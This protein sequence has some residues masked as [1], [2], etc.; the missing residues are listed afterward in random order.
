MI[1]NKKS[2]YFFR[3][4][5][6]LVL[7][8]AAFILAA[9]L[10]QSWD[11]L[12]S[13]N[14]M[15]ILMMGLNFIWYFTST[16][17]NFYDDFITRL[18]AYQVVNIIKS[19]IVQAL[20][21]VLF[22]F[23]LKENL[24]TRNFIVYYS[25]FLFLFI[26]FRSLTFRTVMKRIRQRGKNIR[27]LLIIGTGEV[28]RNFRKLLRENPDFGYNFIGFL[29]KDN[30]DSRELI[31]EIS[32]EL[33]GSYNQ[34]EEILMEKKVEEI[35]IALPDYE[36]FLLDNIIRIC[37][38]NA[39]RIHI[40]PDYFRYVSKRFRISM[41]ENFPIITS[42]N[43]PL[44]EIQWKFVKRTFDII[45]SLVVT[46]LLLSYLIPLIALL[47]KL[48][49]KGPVFFVQDRIGV[50][51]KKFKCYKF[52]TLKE[53][54]TSDKEFLPVY[55]DDPRVTPVGNLLRKSNLD[56][57][58]QFINVLKGDMS[59]VGPRP[60]AIPYDDKYG[61]I[62]E[63]IKLRHS[64]KPGITGWAQAHGLRGDVE[65]EEENRIRT[66]KRIEYDLWYIENWSFWLDIQIIFL[67]IWRMIKGETKAV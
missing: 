46:L 42:R 50:R 60:H 17:I 54:I 25:V 43:E 52:R 12:L 28:A 15:F 56:E 33:I 11:T 29:D 57:L 7:L 67:T 5:T 37:N 48:T 32:S 65:D 59:V 13:R 26:S 9:I 14:Y 40:I 55:K 31:P 44:D 18:F 47:T 38:R 10:A 22:I 6:D 36:P 2:I 23:L 64:V 51:N 1:V 19:V 34:L 58:P 16:I 61:Q 20:A 8:N 66:I 35:V 49:S 53:N 27:N 30:S 62:I 4:F 45:F 63:E 24:F 3:L 41:I 39:V 21:S